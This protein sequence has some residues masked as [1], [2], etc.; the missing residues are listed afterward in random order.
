MLK[1]KNND[2]YYIYLKIYMLYDNLPDDIID[3]IYSKIIFKKN[4]EFCL[5][6]KIHYYIMNNLFKTKNIKDILSCLIIHKN[7]NITIN[8]INEISE[9]I[10][11]YDEKFIKLYIFNLLKKLSI[12]SKLDFIFYINDYSINLKKMDNYYIKNKILRVINNF[13]YK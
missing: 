5:E 12:D 11:N 6:I 9:K 7:N 2:F 10:D 4:K 13:I 8:E 3:Y 1:K